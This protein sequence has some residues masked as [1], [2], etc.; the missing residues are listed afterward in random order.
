MVRMHSPQSLRQEAKALKAIVR[1]IRVTSIVP[2]IVRTVADFLIHGAGIPLFRIRFAPEKFSF[3]ACGKAML[4][5][6]PVFK[7][8]LNFELMPIALSL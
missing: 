6:F 4:S 7:P 5:A 2:A 3:D 8:W 1:M